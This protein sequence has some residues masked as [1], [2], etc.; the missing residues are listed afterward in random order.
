MRECIWVSGIYKMYC[1]AVVEVALK[2]L[3]AGDDGFLPLSCSGYH[4]K[5]SL[6]YF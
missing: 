4:F 2:V 3:V 1:M 6:P 5:V